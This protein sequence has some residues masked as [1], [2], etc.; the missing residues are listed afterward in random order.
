MLIVYLIIP[1][2][3]FILVLA[4]IVLWCRTRKE[5][6]LNIAAREKYTRHIDMT[7][8][9]TNTQNDITVT[10]TDSSGSKYSKNKVMPIDHE[11]LANEVH[12]DPKM[13]N[14]AW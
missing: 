11:K 14:S 1:V 7:R 9:S 6:S 8:R 3:L 13:L 2:I 12:I 10:S 4:I 5:E